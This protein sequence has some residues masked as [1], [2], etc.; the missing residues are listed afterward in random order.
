MQRCAEA[1]E[2]LKTILLPAGSKRVASQANIENQD[3]P[4][5]KV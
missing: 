3:E 4:Q 2:R 5:S 1:S